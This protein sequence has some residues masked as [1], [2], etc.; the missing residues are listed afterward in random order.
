MLKGFEG[1]RTV[2]IAKR[3]GVGHP[4]LHYHFSTKEALFHHVIREKMGLLVQSVQLSLVESNQSFPEKLA[5]AI[6]QHFDFVRAHV[7]YIRFLIHEMEKHPD[8]FADARQE[9]HDL[10]S[11]IAEHLQ[12]DLDASAKRGEI[13]PMDA[14]VL[15]EDIIVLNVFFQVAMPIVQNIRQSEYGNDYLEK[16]KQENINLILNRLLVKRE[17]SLSSA[18]SE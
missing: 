17:P 5:Q 15:L 2:E 16:R 12:K 13:V 1:A 7:D 8:L 18:K 14:G 6:S 3:A 11:Q 10:Q 4:L 9:A